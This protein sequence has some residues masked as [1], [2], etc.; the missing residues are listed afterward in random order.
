VASFEPQGLIED[1]V[2]VRAVGWTGDE[3]ATN[4]GLGVDRVQ[5]VGVGR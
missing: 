2:E 4:A 5:T 1:A 3:E